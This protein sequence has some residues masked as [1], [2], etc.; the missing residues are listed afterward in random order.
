MPKHQKIIDISWPLTQKSTSYRNRSLFKMSASKTFQT[1]HMR[2]TK[3]TLSSHSGTHIDAPSHF[4]KDGITI[5]K[6]SLNKFVGTA[7]VID[8]T[9]LKKKIT[10]SDFKAHKIKKNQIILLKTH[11][12][13]LNE[14]DQ[15]DSEF[16]YLTASG[17]KYL[18][19]KK[20]KAVGI[21]YLGIEHSDS[22]HKTHKILLKADIPIIEGLRLANTKAKEYYFI[23]LPLALECIDAAPARAILIENFNFKKCN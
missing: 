8:F 7:E 22:Y 10:A 17:A 4:L 11:N 6:E 2:E 3:I 9:K 14:T 1:D 19:E 12:S 21:D 23:C 5:D 16:I 20:V 18:K 15:F 13:F